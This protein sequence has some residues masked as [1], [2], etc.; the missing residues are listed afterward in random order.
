[1]TRKRGVRVEGGVAFLWVLGV[2]A[3]GGT[4]DLQSWMGDSGGAGA[5]GGPGLPGFS[6]SGAIPA[7]R[8]GKGSATNAGSGGAGGRNDA[9]SAGGTGDTYAAAGSAGRA[10]NGDVT[11]AGFGGNSSSAGTAGTAGTSPDMG[12]PYS[13]E[14]YCAVSGATCVNDWSDARTVDSWCSHSNVSELSVWAGCEG[15]N[16]VTVAGTDETGLF[17]SPGLYST[18]FYDPDTGQLVHINSGLPT[19]VCVAGEPDPMFAPS[20]CSNYAAFTC[21]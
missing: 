17:G 16:A 1:M 4:V 18:Y 7:A 15:F 14:Q 11:S 2:A 20:A 6:G 8:G 3:C 19:P 5:S 13:V 9:P 12:C 21:P 10:S